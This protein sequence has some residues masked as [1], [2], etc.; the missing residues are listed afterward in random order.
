MI[1]AM[2]GYG[3]MMACGAGELAA[4]HVLSQS[5]YDGTFLDF[6][7]AKLFVFIIIFVFYFS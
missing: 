4:L 3:V 1:G 7:L 5:V 2:S 6:D